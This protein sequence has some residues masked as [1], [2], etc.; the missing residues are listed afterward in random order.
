MTYRIINAD[1]LDFL[2]DNPSNNSDLFHAFLSDLPYEIGFMNHG[3]D[4]SGIT[5][6]RTFWERVR[7]WMMP[8]ALCFAFTSGRYWHRVSTAIEDAGFDLHYSMWA[9]LKPNALQKGNRI[10]TKIDKEL[11]LEREIIGYKSNGLGRLN[12]KNSKRGY[13]PSAYSEGNDFPI[14]KPSSYLAQAWEGHRYGTMSLKPLIEPILVFQAPYDT[15]DASRYKNMAE[16]GTGA[17]NIDSVRISE[18][19]DIGRWPSNVILIH[20]ESCMSNENGWICVDDCPIKQLNASDGDRLHKGGSSNGNAPIGTKSDGSTIAYRRG[21]L[22]PH[23]DEGQASMFFDTFG[24]NYE[25]EMK[26]AETNPAIFAPSTSTKER[27][28]G[29]DEQ[30]VSHSAIKPIKVTE[31]LAKLLLPPEHYKPRKLFVPFSGTGSEIVGAQMAGWDDITGIE[32]IPE[33]VEISKRKIE[34]FENKRKA[35]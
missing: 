22:V 31:H 24:W 34:F 16:R 29:F 27:L 6:Q 5:F 21:T 19:G 25:N 15:N 1:V 7:K 26:I 14:T 2:K 12:I 23:N 9:W 32:I 30:S 18:N 33:Y 17:Y 8:G 20:D 35:S 10:D 3:W 13:R 28:I 4:K 11:G